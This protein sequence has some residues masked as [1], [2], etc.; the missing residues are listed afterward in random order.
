MSI[1][2]EVTAKCEGMT[3]RGLPCRKNA[4]VYEP[5]MGALATIPEIQAHTVPVTFYATYRDQ[6]NIIP[7]GFRCDTHS[8]AGQEQMWN[9][10]HRNYR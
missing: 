2:I 4:K 8:K 5:T 10:I 1:T 9:R 7:T 6:H 3:Q